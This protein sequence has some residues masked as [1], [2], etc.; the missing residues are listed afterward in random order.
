GAGQQTVC[1]HRHGQDLDVV[2][3][4]VVASVQGG[5]GT[6]RTHQVQGST[7]RGTQGQ[8][9]AGSGGVDQVDDVAP[10]PGGHVNGP[11]L[12]EQGTDLCGVGGG[13]QRLERETRAVR[14]DHV[15]LGLRRRIAHRDA[16]HET[17][18]L[19]LGQ[20]VGALHVGGVLCGDHHEGAFQR[21]GPSVDTDLAFFHALQK[22]G[23]GFGGG[24]VDLVTEHDI[25]K[26]RTG[27]EFEFL[28]VLVE[29]AHPG[30]V[31]G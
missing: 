31:T 10:Y 23:L 21:S 6:G 7:W 4:H 29:D 9:G 17:V 22:G 12:V 5:V 27:V 13:L 30:D 19:C 15:Q 2:G 20:C 25:G 3:H 8:L 28:A 24:P 18:P 11:Y 16:G 26:H 14:V 1:E